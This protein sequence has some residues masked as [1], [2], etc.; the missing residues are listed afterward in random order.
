MLDRLEERGL[1]NRERA[2]GDRRVVKVGV[3]AAGLALLRRLDAEVRACHEHQLGHLSPKQ[4]HALI[5]LL[6][7]ARQPH[8]TAESDWL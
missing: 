4:L 6:R 8:E 2:A 3:T 1:I 7:T 5:D